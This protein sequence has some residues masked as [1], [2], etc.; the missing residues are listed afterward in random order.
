MKKERELILFLCYNV[1]RLAE[2]RK[3]ENFSLANVLLFIKVNQFITRVSA[4]I[5][6]GRCCMHFKGLASIVYE[7][8]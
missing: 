7:R 8:K 6:A 2:V 3:L 5:L 1:N 4:R